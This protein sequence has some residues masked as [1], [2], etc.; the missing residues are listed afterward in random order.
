MH[1]GNVLLLENVTTL[2]TALKELVKTIQ[3]KASKADVAKMVEGRVG[4]LED[5][6]NT[7]LEEDNDALAGTC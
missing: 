6:V 7:V 1:I 2:Q 5:A 3:L 4:Y